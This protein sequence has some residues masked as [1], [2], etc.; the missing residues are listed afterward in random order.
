MKS[1]Y[2]QILIRSKYLHG[3]EISTITLYIHDNCNMFQEKWYL[4]FDQAIGRGFLVY[5]DK[6]IFDI[7][8]QMLS[9][10]LTLYHEI[11]MSILER[12]H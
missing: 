1:L 9:A 10:R 7:Y 12:L 8:P 4:H 11:I 5:L 6:N 3:K 2:S